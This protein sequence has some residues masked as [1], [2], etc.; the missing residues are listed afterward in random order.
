[1]PTCKADR[2]VPLGFQS[3]S[4]MTAAQRRLARERRTIEAM[5][6]LFCRQ[7]HASRNGLCSACRELT[8][9]ARQRLEKCPF[10]DDKPTCARCPVHCY[11]PACREQIRM[12]MRHAGP[13]I[14]F[15]R[16]I[17]VIR[18]KLDA[19]HVV[20]AAPRRRRPEPSTRG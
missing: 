11:K 7:Q 17:L 2:R 5:I 10:Q 13:R 1:M 14:L 19:R 18:H 8:T 12:V 3:V 16:P 15:R 9:Y 20:P 6:A 4:T